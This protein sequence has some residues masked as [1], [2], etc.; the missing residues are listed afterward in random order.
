MWLGSLVH[1]LI[2]ENVSMNIPDIENYWQS[3]TTVVFLGRKMPLHIMIL[4]E[5]SA[6]ISCRTDNA[7]QITSSGSVLCELQ[8]NAPTYSFRLTRDS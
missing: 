7:V 5:L 4:C 8:F 2:I 6:M 3:Q 1:G